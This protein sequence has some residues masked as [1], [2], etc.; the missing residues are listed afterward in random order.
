M[1]IASST[2]LSGVNVAQS[3][4]ILNLNKYEIKL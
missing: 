2:I 1:S 4:I 3:T